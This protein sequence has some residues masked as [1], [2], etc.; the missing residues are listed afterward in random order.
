MKEEWKPIKDYEGLYEV[1]NTGKV[2][3][4]D[5]VVEYTGRR[6][7]ET[8]LHKG[9]EIKATLKKSGYWQVSLNKDNIRKSFRLHRLVAAAFVINSNPDKF[10]V[11]NHLDGNKSNNC[12]DNLEW[13]DNFGNM[14]HAA[15][16]NLLNFTDKK[17]E[18]DRKNI[19]KINE[20]RKLSVVKLTLD[21]EYVDTY[22]SLAAAAKSVKSNN[23]NLV[24]DAC[25]G[26]RDNYKGFKW[27]FESDYNT[28]C[29]A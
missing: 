28:N 5:R 12:A 25:R 3:S 7:G 13:T 1:S 10:D 17:R 29:Q 4:L 18:S 27:V 16:N 9:H 8:R 19:S 20:Q 22:E 21:G 15:A 6:T 2:R 11:V 14:Q 23:G 24:A 26:K